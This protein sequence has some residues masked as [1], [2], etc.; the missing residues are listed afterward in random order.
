MDKVAHRQMLDVVQFLLGAGEI[1]EQFAVLL[2]Q[3]LAWDPRRRIST[4]E[5]LIVHAGAMCQAQ[6]G[7][8]PE[9]EQ[10]EGV[11]ARQVALVRWL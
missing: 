3:T 6:S 7:N 10:V 2:Q 4:S 1:E 8:C 11:R 9:R 5:A